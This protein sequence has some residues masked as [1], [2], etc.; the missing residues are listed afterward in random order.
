[1]PMDSTLTCATAGP[2]PVALLQSIVESMG[3]GIAV[4]DLNGKFLLFNPAAE[5]ILGVGAADIPP[6]QWAE[7]YGVYYPGTYRLYPTEQMP[8]NRAIRGEDTNQVELLIRNPARPEGV[9]ISV[10]GRPLRDVDGNVTGGVVVLRDITDQKSAEEQ[11]RYQNMLL[12]A[13][14]EHIPDQIYFKDRNSRFMCV[15][16]AVAE[17]FGLSHPREAVGKSDA[18]FFLEEH[19]RQTV[20]DEQLVMTNRQPII[21]LE[22]K[23]TWPDGRV[24][25]DLSTKMPLYDEHGMVIGTFGISR[26][27]TARKKAEE[28]L[29]K[30]SQALEQTADAVI[31]LDRSGTIE[32]VNPAFTHM[33]GY[34]RAEAL[35]QSPR[36]LHRETDAEHIERELWQ[37]LKKGETQRRMRAYRRKDGAVLH[38]DETIT[39][40]RD[41]ANDI[42]QFVVTSKDMTETR[43][44]FEELR[45]SRERYMLAVEGSKDGLWDWDL[46]TNEVYYS[47]RCKAMLGCD[48][49]ELPNR[50]DAWIDRLHPDDRP[51][52]AS[53][54]QAYLDNQFADY[55][56]EMRMR[57]RDGSYRWILTRGVAFRRAEGKPYRMAGSHT[58]ITER[59]KNEEALRRARADAEAASKAKNQFL[60]NVSHEIR[61]PMHGILGMTELALS[62]ELTRGQREYLQMVKTSANAL[63]AVINDVLDFSKMEA[64]KIDIDAEVFSLHDLLGDTVKSL[65]LRAHSK[66]LELACR[67][68]ADVPDWVVGDDVRLRQVLIN[69]AGN[70]IKFTEEGEVVVAVS[71]EPVDGADSPD[72]FSVKFEVQDTG[73]GIPVDKQKLIFDPFVQADGAMNRRYGGTGLGLSISTRLVEL[74]GGTMHLESCEGKGSTF[75]FVL[76]LQRGEP[77]ERTEALPAYALKGLR[78]LVV[79]DNATNRLIL[80]EMTRSWGMIPTVASDGPSALAALL[81]AEKTGTFALVL[82]DAMMPDVDGF[83]LAEQIQQHPEMARATIMMLTSAD[84]LGDS[85]RCRELGI[86]SYL[87]K[88]IKASELLDA[89]VNVLGASVA[90]TIDQ[91][92]AGA[93]E[94]VAKSPENPTLRI[95][96]AEDNPINQMLVRGLLE[97]QGH[98]PLLVSNG[99]EAVEAFGREPFDLVL[100]DV[101]MPVMDGFEA[102]RRLRELQREMRRHTPIIAMTAHAMKGDRERCLEMGMDGY[103]AKPLSAVQLQEALS[104]F[105]GSLVHEPTREVSG[106]DGRLVDMEAALACVGGDQNLLRSMADLYQVEEPRM[107]KELAEAVLSGDGPRLRRAAHTFKS[108]LGHLGATTSATLLAELEAMGQAGD[109]SQARETLSRFETMLQKL[110]P[111]I[112]A[113][114]S[115]AAKR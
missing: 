25:W 67:I 4:A 75:S 78:V 9:Y 66:G 16:R 14:M 110:G 58:D 31:I 104:G 50:L 55:E 106:I 41:V 71:R 93:D 5:R 29:L 49:A 69:L 89:V 103:L 113:L 40:L 61:T 99:K 15:S 26:D 3:D 42:T 65:A 52:A 64:G 28:Q 83:T 73:I 48:D 107:R 111:E 30:L 70:A 86:A 68:E 37:L 60:S 8:L 112:S 62:T 10:T 11:V 57:H 98:V 39:P 43:R 47:P 72:M 94:S 17:R 23:E 97:K 12:Q 36:L 38:A 44:A 109:L 27:I 114:G 100:M 59:K 87:T 46:E 96:V 92:A 2:L 79:D 108:A 105:A 24:T 115:G 77:R 51:Q 91:R 13:L 63:L 35:G 102:T 74:M 101:Q 53:V 33:T 18:D 90:D 76:P 95:L 85:S 21:D 1:M 45:K 81:A 6:D 88:P 80:A 34:E 56:V 22:E 7:V 84:Q 19:A 20:L 32:Y 82:L 54:L